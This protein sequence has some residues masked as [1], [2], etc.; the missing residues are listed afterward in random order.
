MRASQP[1]RWPR[2]IRNRKRL[3]LHERC[4]LRLICDI[5]PLDA[6]VCHLRVEIRREAERRDRVDIADRAGSG[7]HPRVDWVAFGRVGGGVSVFPPEFH[8]VVLVGHHR[9]GGGSFAPAVAAD[10]GVG[11]EAA[12][13]LNGDPRVLAVVPGVLL[14]GGFV[15]G[16]PNV[17]AEALVEG[18]GV[19]L[20]VGSGEFG[21]VGVAVIVAFPTGLESGR[22]RVHGFEVEFAEWA[23]FPDVGCVR[24]RYLFDS[25][26][27]VD[28]EDVELWLV[29]SQT[30]NIQEYHLQIVCCSDRQK[31]PR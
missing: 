13:G 25:V 26:I 15:G 12:P 27:L 17:H 8:V 18:L 31:Q 30:S 14:E 4:V 28:V 9:V 16:V 5:I 7:V 2:R 24:V 11:V 19:D 22:G 29:S 23:G 10:A 6:L 20:A 3:V 1:K 21:V